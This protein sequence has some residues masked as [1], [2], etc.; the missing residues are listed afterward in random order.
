MLAEAIKA[1][2]ELGQ[3]SA[4]VDFHAHPALPNRVFIRHG[5]E[6]L[7]KDA[8]PPLRNHQLEGFDDLVR[9]LE[10]EAIAPAPEVYVSRVAV[11]ALLNRGERREAVSVKLVETDRFKILRR[12]QSAPALMDPKQVIKLL[13]FDLHSVNAEAVIQGLRKVNFTRT[14]SGAS[15]VEHGRETLGRSVEASVQQA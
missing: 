4:A 11:V 2:V 3:D 12:L 9:A 8:P 13:R 15:N 5:D 1:I 6:L 14:S 10:D 7:E